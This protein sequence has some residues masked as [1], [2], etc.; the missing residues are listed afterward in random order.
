MLEY[1]GVTGLLENTAELAEKDTGSDVW[2]S[3]LARW[4][5]IF[6][7]KPILMRPLLVE[8]WKDEDLAE[9]MPEEVAE[10][11]RGQKTNVAGIKVGQALAKKTDV[12][13]SNGLKLIKGHDAHKDQNTW[14]V[15]K[16]AAGDKQVVGR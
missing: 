2:N 14:A 11:L 16:A 12:T 3:F 6:G 15:E 5:A 10:A 4:H 8:L 13:Y 1:A 9:V 7:P